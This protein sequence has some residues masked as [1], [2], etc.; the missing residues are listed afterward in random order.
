MQ[1][2]HLSYK[3]PIYPN[4]E[5][6]HLI[7]K[8]IDAATD[9]WNFL[10][11][12]KMKTQKINSVFNTNQKTPNLLPRF[13][14][15]MPK[16][17][18]LPPS[19]FMHV[20]KTIDILFDL[21]AKRK[22]GKLPK[23]KNKNKE[24]FSTIA[25]YNGYKKDG[26]E[27]I[28]VDFKNGVVKLPFFGDIKV[29]FTRRFVGKIKS[30]FIKRGWNKKYFLTLVVEVSTQ[31]TN[32]TGSMCGID[33]GLKDYLT[34]VYN[35]GSVEKISFPEYNIES[36]NKIEKLKRK[37]KN[38]KNEQIKNKL[39]KAINKEKNKVTNKWKDYINKITKKI[40][41][42]N[43]V[44]AI[45]DLDIVD[46]KN[47]YKIKK[48]NAARWAYFSHCMKYKSKLYNKK[49]VLV[50]NLFPSSKLCSVCGYKNDKLTIND[51][52]WRCPSCK[53]MHDRDENAARNLL[54][55]AICK[56]KN[57]KYFGKY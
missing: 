41:M 5:I 8:A 11:D 21:Y 22:V 13:F 6:R 52:Q 9:Y 35:D 57:K 53:T 46:L 42:Q 26:S 18:Y 36:K 54:Q 10:L 27:V 45:E 32:K 25:L 49:L 15:L 28:S 43:D 34:I 2:T 50:D 30:C 33:F 51:R 17:N 38:A 37:I 39:A 1:T 48:M 14:D 31:N 47:K 23:H 40:V 56:L 7:E 19:I 20:R 44:I 24:K 55:Y 12:Y 4:D 3:F 29:K 16:Y